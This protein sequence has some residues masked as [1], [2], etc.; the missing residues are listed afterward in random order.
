MG[1]HY[2]SFDYTSDYDCLDTIPFQILYDME[3]KLNGFVFQ[4]IAGL[5]GS[6]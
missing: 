2:F 6:L 5:S 3:G 4:H 1:T